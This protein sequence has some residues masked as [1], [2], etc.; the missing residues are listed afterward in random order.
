[1]DGVPGS[2][3]KSF[4]KVAK[5]HLPVSFKENPDLLHHITTQISPSLLYKHNISVCKVIQEPGSFVVTFPQAYHGGF[6]SGV[7]VYIYMCVCVFMGMCV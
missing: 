5:L 6:S 3:A 2:Q 1:M 7:S 4:E